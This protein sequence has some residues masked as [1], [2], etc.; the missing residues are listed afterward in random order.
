MQF[1]KS[2]R[3]SRKADAPSRIVDPAYADIEN[4]DLFSAQWYLSRYPDVADTQSD[5]VEHFLNNGFRERRD[6]GPWFSTSAYLR[7]NPDVEK[8][9]MNALVHYIRHGNT[10]GREGFSVSPRSQYEDLNGFLDAS[11]IDPLFNAPFDEPTMRAFA[12]MDVLT[13]KHAQAA[14]D[15]PK[16]QRPLVSIVMPVWNRESVIAQAIASV[17]SQTYDRFELL[18]V[19]DGSDDGTENVIGSFDDE[20]IV[21]MRNE[22]QSGVSFSR[23]RALASA[24]G[25]LIAYLD[26]DNT[27]LPNYLAAT[28]MAFVRRPDVETIYSG[29]YV[30][31]GS[32]TRPDAVRFGS[33][34]VSLLDNRNYID[35]NCLMHRAAMDQRIGGYFREDMT[36]LVDWEL[37]LRLA[38]RSK[39][40]SLPIL[41]CNYFNGRVDNT[42]TQTEDVGPALAAVMDTSMRCRA[43][44]AIPPL[45]ASVSIVIVSYQAL[46]ELRRCLESVLALTDRSAVDVIVID[47]NSS[48]SVTQYISRMTRYGVISEVLDRNYGFSYAVNRGVALADANSDIFLLNNDASLT[49][50]ALEHLQQAA[51]EHED[52]GITVPRQIVPAHNDS[53]HLHVPY[54][55]RQFPVDVTLSRHHQNLSSTELERTNTPLSLLFAPFFCAYIKR[56]VWVASGGLD[57][58]RGRHYRSDRIMCDYVRSVLGKRVVYVH[59]AIVHHEVQAATRALQSEAGTAASSYEEMLL[60]NRWP[61]DLAEELGIVRAPWML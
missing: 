25:S 24:R 17:L 28:V 20:R 54:A 2:K 56:E 41:Q 37:T 45:R 40:M 33:V 19:D 38:T 12:M 43:C 14:C 4:S 13:E 48:Q 60:A 58:G 46:D 16:S 44:Y 61:D 27:W 8:A 34:N 18:L 1:F 31:H 30:Y 39:I 29:Q 6:P 52:V 3:S 53:I 57:H 35:L 50:G 21:L 49:A 51:Y 55:D 23:N 5:P 42:I 9:G 59:Q 26:S 36:R 22:T 10:E 11:T 15:L 32:A 7:A 47:N